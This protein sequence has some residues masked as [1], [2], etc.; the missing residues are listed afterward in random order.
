MKNKIGIRERERGIAL[1]SALL[2]LLVLTTLSAGIIFVTQSGTW[3]AMNYKSATQA[4]FEAEAGLQRTL[5][6]FNTS[7]AGAGV[8]YGTSTDGN[9]YPTYNG[10]PVV[11]TAMS[12]ASSNYP[13]TSVSSSY[14]TTLNPTLSATG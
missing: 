4:R 14:N 6:W 3:S 7:Y 5:Q 9:A 1:I 12:G 8:T 10:Q 13:T 2:Y 11:L